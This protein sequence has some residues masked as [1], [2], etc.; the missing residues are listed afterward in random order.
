MIFNVNYQKRRNQ[1]LFLTL[2]NKHTLFLSKTQN[3]IPLY[4]RFFTLTES[5]YKNVNLNHTWYLT[6]VKEKIYCLKKLRISVMTLTI[7]K[8]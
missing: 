1:E 4:D 3:Y 5:N 8:S 7:L 6:S 2:E